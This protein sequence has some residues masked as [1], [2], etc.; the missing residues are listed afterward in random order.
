MLKIWATICLTKINDNINLFC[1]ISN[2]IFEWLQYQT[3]L[4]NIGNHIVAC[5]FILSVLSDIV[6]V[7]LYCHQ[8]CNGLVCR[9]YWTKTLST[10]ISKSGVNYLMIIW[11]IWNPVPLFELFDS[12]FDDYFSLFDS[13]KWWLFDT[14]LN[15]I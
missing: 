6:N 8:Y 12:L 14:Y 2:N 15:I 4:N 1:T 7:F 11:F 3:I 13:N 5:C 10:I 9:W